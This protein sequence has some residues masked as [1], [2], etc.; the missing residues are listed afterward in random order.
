MNYDACKR[1]KRERRY[2]EKAV[3]AAKELSSSLVT[4]GY[5][6]GLNQVL[7]DVAI[8]AVATALE[9]KSP[10][11]VSIQSMSLYWVCH[12]AYAYS[13]LKAPEDLDLAWA[14]KNLAGTDD[15]LRYLVDESIRPMRKGLCPQCAQIGYC[16]FA[17]GRIVACPRCKGGRRGLKRL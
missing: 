3:E 11:V 13:M 12:A 7:L 9:K 8:K 5:E 6:E 2:L 1:L 16:L 10:K 15:E 17:G 4:D 14:L